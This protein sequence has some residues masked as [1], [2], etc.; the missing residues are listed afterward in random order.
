VSDIKKIEAAVATLA[1]QFGPNTVVQLGKRNALHV[2][3]IPTGVLSIDNALGVGGVPRGR[4]VEVYGGEMGGKTTLTLQIIAQAQAAG[5]AAAFIDAEHALDTKYAAVL[6]VDTA[7]L[8]VAQPDSGEMALETAEGLIKSGEFDIVVIDSVAAL[9]PRAELEGEMGDSQMGLQARLMSQAMRKLTGC[10]SKTKTCLVFINQVRDKIGIAY[11]CLHG[12]ELIRFSDGVVLPIRRVVR[13]RIKGNVLTVDDT[14]AVVAKPIVGWYENGRLQPEERWHTI[15]TDSAG[16]SGGVTAICVTADHVLYT[17]DGKEVRAKDVQEGDKLLSYSTTGRLDSPKVKSILYG[18]LL[19]DGHLSQ[20][21]KRNNTQFR[22]ANQEQPEYLHWKLCHLASLGFSKTGNSYRPTYTSKS[23]NE[24][25]EVRKLFYGMCYKNGKNYRSIPKGLVLDDLTVAVWYMD[26]GCSAFD[27]SHENGRPQICIKRMV[28][29]PELIELA[30]QK[31]NTWAGVPMFHYCSPNRKL[32]VVSAYKTLFYSKIASFIPSCMQYKLPEE[33]RA[34]YKEL[35]EYTTELKLVAV[36]VTV[37]SVVVGSVK[38]HRQL[39]KFDIQVAGSHKYFAGGKLAGLLFHNSPEVTTGGRAL[40]FFASQRIEVRRSTLLK[41]GDKVI[42]AVTKIKVVKNKLASPFQ[43][44]EV[45]MI[46]GH[47][48]SQLRD[49]VELGVNQGVV[50]KSG[51]WYSYAGERI[52][53]GKANT[54]EFLTANPDLAKKL[55]IEVRNK[56]MPP[57]EKTA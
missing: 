48:L 30:L 36:P 16:A 9:V 41:D 23:S 52:G 31:L 27:D 3:V 26:D 25:S 18:S 40:R 2:A 37:K 14:G 19:G 46:F 49:L 44:C 11:G 54:V 32:A 21:K 53:Q 50:E 29:H 57:E 55:F 4:I 1:K 51:A 35:P 13:E 39:A 15:T 10:V 47:G 24:L 22:L 5:G 28:N 42:G 56:V 20:G 33:W 43:E 7:N 38:K 17:A 12:D 45:D 8:W 6:G 34:Q